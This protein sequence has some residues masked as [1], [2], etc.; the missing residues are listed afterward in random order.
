MSVKYGKFELPTKVKVEEDEDPNRKARI[1]AGPFERGF[2][3]T[4]GNSLTKNY[5][6]KF[7]STGNCFCTN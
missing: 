4:I 3:H 1:I 7:R 6:N 5:V 2:G